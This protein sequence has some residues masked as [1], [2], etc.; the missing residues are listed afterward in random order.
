VDCWIASAT[1]FRLRTEG[2]ITDP[3]DGTTYA[4]CEATLADLSA[5]EKSRR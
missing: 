3:E 4:T 1:Q 2:K 5:I